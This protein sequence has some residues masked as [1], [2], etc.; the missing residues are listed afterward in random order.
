MHQNVKCLQDKRCSDFVDT[1]GRAHT[2]VD[3]VPAFTAAVLDER[4]E[5]PQTGSV[6]CEV[7]E[8]WTDER[9]RELV[10][11]STERPWAISATDGESEFVVERRQV[12]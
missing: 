6:A 4:S 11:V 9:G 1:E 3:K 5:Y 7:L 2:I 12:E 8:A 10:R